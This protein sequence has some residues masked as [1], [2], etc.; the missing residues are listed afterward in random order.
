MHYLIDGH[1][2]IAS[3]PDIDLSDP[4]DEVQLIMRLRRWIAAGRRR[5]ITLFFDGGLPGGRAPHYSGGSLDVIFASSGQEA[6]RL[7]VRRIRQV[8]NPPEFTLVTSDR[9]ILANAQSRGM[10]AIDSQTFARQ[11]ESELKTR[12]QSGPDRSSKERPVLG[13]DELAEWLDIFGS[14]DDT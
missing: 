9:E 12:S 11:V 3:M 2:L 1:N 8:R 6:D 14:A 10:P 13:A 5:R 4:D 7:L